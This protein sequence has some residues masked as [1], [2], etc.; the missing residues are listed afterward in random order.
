VNK[1]L[2]IFTIFTIISLVILSYAQK[3][4]KIVQEKE[5]MVYIPA[6]SF[7]MGSD[8][9]DKE[10]DNDEKP[11]HK[12]YLDAYYIDKYEVTNAQYKECVNAGKCKK[13]YI[14]YITDLL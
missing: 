14:T 9:S 5:N 6:G 7:C 13:P 10:A 2:L 1:K 12:V 11:K 8:D 4:K 3:E